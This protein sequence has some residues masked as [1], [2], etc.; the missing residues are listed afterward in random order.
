MFCYRNADFPGSI[1]EHFDVCTHFCLFGYWGKVRLYF[2][3][4]MFWYPSKKIS[5]NSELPM[6]ES[7]KFAEQIRQ[8]EAN[9]ANQ[10][11]QIGRNQ[12]SLFCKSSESIIDSQGESGKYYK[13]TNIFVRFGRI[14]ICIFAI[15]TLIPLIYSANLQSELG[16]SQIKLNQSCDLPN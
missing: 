13:Y 8:I 4:Q 6:G 16:K 15:L 5:C 11:M 10:I 1:S 3:I 12:I 7:G 9:R 14:Y 2:D